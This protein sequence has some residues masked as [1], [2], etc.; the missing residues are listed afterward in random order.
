MRG[1]RGNKL[2]GMKDT[3]KIKK[4]ILNGRWIYINKKDR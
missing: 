2:E 3:R 1:R 4:I